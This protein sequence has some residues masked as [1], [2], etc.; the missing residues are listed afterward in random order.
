MQVCLPM[1]IFSRSFFYCGYLYSACSQQ[2]QQLQQ[3]WVSF[4]KQLL[5]ITTAIT[6]IVLVITN[7]FQ[8]GLFVVISPHS[9]TCFVFLVEFFCIPTY[10]H[11]LFIHMYFFKCICICVYIYTSIIIYFFFIKQNKVKRQLL[12]VAVNNLVA[13]TLKRQPNYD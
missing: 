13:A 12:L 5:A 3:L 7:L 9:Q 4:L 2:L 11:T 8:L 1:C 10:I 6:I